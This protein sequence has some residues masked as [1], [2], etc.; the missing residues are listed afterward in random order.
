MSVIFAAIITTVMVG[1]ETRCFVV[2]IAAHKYR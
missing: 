1:I 2:I